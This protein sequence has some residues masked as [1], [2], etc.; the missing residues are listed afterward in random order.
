MGSSEDDM[1]TKMSKDIQ[2]HYPEKGK[3]ALVCI[4]DFE[5]PGE[6]LYTSMV[7]DNLEDALRELRRSIK[8]VNCMVYD[9][10]GNVYT[11]DSGAKP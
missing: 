9:S 6:Q 4:D 7:Y 5:E 2:R 8:V 1:L 10:E 3:F 11:G